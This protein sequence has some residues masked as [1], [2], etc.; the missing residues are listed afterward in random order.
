MQQ[1]YTIKSGKIK[2]EVSALG[3]TVRRFTSWEKDIFYPRRIIKGKARGGC[4]FCAPW[5]G[6][7]P[8]GPKKHGF[9]RDIKATGWRFVD[10]DFI[11]LKFHESPMQFYPWRIDYASQASVVSQGI[12]NMSFSAE[13]LEDGVTKDAPFLGGFHP[14]FACEDAITAKI[15]VPRS[16]TFYSVTV[17]EAKMFPLVGEEIIITVPHEWELV[18]KLRGD[19][20]RY[21]RPHFVIWTDSLKYFCVEPILQDKNLFDT[22]KGFHLSQNE[23][24]Y[25]EVSFVV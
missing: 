3:G 18:M 4:H 6:S 16:N 15:Y 13:R 25:L 7:S 8:K 17:G 11:G 19:F 20:F 22:P 1:L 14:Y 9:L 5:F 12:L 24:I 23:K 2:A 10:Q 21:D